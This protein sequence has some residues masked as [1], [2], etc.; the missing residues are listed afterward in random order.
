VCIKQLLQ[1]DPE[2]RAAKVESMKIK[3]AK[4]EYNLRSKKISKAI[5]NKLFPSSNISSHSGN[6]ADD[7]DQSNTG[8]E[9]IIKEDAQ[10]VEEPPISLGTMQT[11]EKE[12]SARVLESIETATNAERK[13]PFVFLLGTSLV[14]LVVSLAIAVF[15]AYQK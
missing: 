6:K 15:I 1:L 4:K 3:K 7:L 12:S 10:I 9:N 13:T 5:A 2:N 14:V 11:V 8:K